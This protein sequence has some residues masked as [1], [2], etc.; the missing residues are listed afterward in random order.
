MKWYSGDFYLTESPHKT[1]KYL[2]INW[3]TN[4]AVAV[5]KII[6]KPTLVKINIPHHVENQCDAPRLMLSVR[7]K[8]DILIG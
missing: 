5:E 8:E 6:N 2:K 4:P 3:T 7:F 1:I